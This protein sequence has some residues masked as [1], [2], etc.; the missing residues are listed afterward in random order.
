MRY[1]SRLRLS[2]SVVSTDFSI[3]NNDN[4]V[5]AVATRFNIILLEVLLKPGDPYCGHFVS[6]CQSVSQ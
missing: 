2:N 6:V 4:I 3:G 5:G 1:L